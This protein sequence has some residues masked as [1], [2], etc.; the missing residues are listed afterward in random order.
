M[1]LIIKAGNASS[2]SVVPND[3]VKTDKIEDTPKER[4]SK[5]SKK[6]EKE[7]VEKPPSKS[8]IK[9]KLLVLPLETSIIAIILL[10]LLGAF[11]VVI[12]KTSHHSFEV[13][14]IFEPLYFQMIYYFFCT[15]FLFSPLGIYLIILFYFT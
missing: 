6:K 7:P 14:Y 2:E 5:K 8:Q 13:D 10:V 1:L 9:K 12:S 15:C 4:T 11:Y 3:T